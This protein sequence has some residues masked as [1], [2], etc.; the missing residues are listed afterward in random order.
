M[1]ETSNRPL[2][3]ASLETKYMNTTDMCFEMFYVFIN[4]K[5][6]QSSIDGMITS[7]KDSSVQV[8]MMDER[9]K[10]ERLSYAI[11]DKN[12][13]KWRKVTLC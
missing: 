4:D 12:D 13:W 3:S 5:S 7:H 10:W 8:K 11:D 1:A 6:A 9:F 2:Q